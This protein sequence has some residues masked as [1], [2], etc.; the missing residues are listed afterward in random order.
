M[1]IVFAVAAGAANE[2]CFDC[3]DPEAGFNYEALLAF[4]WMSLILA[5]PGFFAGVV[6]NRL[7]A[8][9]PISLRL[10]VVAV[11]SPVFWVLLTMFPWELIIPSTIVACGL[12]FADGLR[13]NAERDSETFSEY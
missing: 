1:L 6:A 7:L 12:S 13:V 2:F 3:P 9:H 10:L 4:L 5:I 11:F 8:Y